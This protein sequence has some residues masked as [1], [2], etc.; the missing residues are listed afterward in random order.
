L[1]SHLSL[2]EAR[3][4]IHLQHFVRPS[5]DKQPLVFVYD[6]N[7]QLLR[8]IEQVLSPAYQLEIFTTPAS[9]LEA[10]DQD[11]IPDLTMLAWSSLDISLKVLQ[12]VTSRDKRH[13]IILLSASSNSEEIARA[14]KLGASG[15]IQKPFHH[16]DLKI[17][18]ERHLQ[19]PPERKSYGRH[20]R[21]TVLDENYTFVRSSRRILEIESQVELIA[22]SDIPVL[23][24]GESGTG[25]EVLARYLH[26]VS[27]RS[28]RM[29]LKLNCAAMPLDLLESELFGYEKGAFTGAMHSKPGKFEI[30]DGGTIFLDEIGEM[31]AVLQAKLLHVLQDGTY[32]RLGGRLAQRSDVRVIAATNI[33]IKAAV[34][35]KTF[36]EDL[37]YRLN[38]FTLTLPPLRERKDEIPVFANHF[39]QKA[40]KK[41][42]K[43]QLPLGPHLL[44]HLER[45]QWP[46][47]LRELENVINRYIITADPKFIVE[48]L[49]PQPTAAT[50]ETITECDL[51]HKSR[52]R[53]LKGN[54][55]SIAIIKMLE[56]TKWNRKEAANRLQISYRT[57]LYKIQQYE[58][59]RN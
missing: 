37:Y 31:P 25:K 17:A 53:K 46:G 47:N 27:Q 41:F 39:M 48:E 34:A 9:L 45:Y 4:S 13:P 22:G 12:D 49:T 43:P 51:D 35:Q 19:R 58:L 56:E 50:T 44:A 28:D 40:S 18:L 7:E 55:E 29:F 11:Q 3:P 15:V 38:G 36:R 2:D 24:L 30:C 20:V 16:G 33:D 14:I 57:L 5:A 10:M 42:N 59:A 23:I 6:P 8:Y 26:S 21:Q 54:V 52:M 32:M 1:K